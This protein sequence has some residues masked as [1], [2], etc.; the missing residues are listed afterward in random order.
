M[1]VASLP[2]P[3]AKPPAIAEMVIARG[4]L[5]AARQGR[6]PAAH[7]HGDDDRHACRHGRSGELR[8]APRR[9]LRR[10]GNG[11]RRVAS[12][13]GRAAR[14][15]GGRVRL[16]HRGTRGARRE[17][18]AG[19]LP[20]GAPAPVSRSRCPRSPVASPSR[21]KRCV[22]VGDVSLAEAE[23]WLAGANRRIFVRRF[24]PR[25][26]D[27]AFRA[28]VAARPAAFP[29]WDRDPASGKVPPEGNE[30]REVN[31]PCVGGSAAWRRWKR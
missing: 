4:W 13:Q 11:E 18:R 7:P 5:K 26:A 9:G 29:E 12:R 20:H 3:D 27:P 28:A 1:H 2:P 15:D 21:P 16:A 31:A 25:L 24:T 17:P 10:V 19:G 6:P 14:R 30:R 22:K 8:R 23:P